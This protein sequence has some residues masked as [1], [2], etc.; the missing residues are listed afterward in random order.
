MVKCA[1]CGFLSVI[2]QSDGSYIGANRLYRL[3]GFQGGQV[4][5]VYCEPHCSIHAQDIHLEPLKAKGAG[6]QLSEIGRMVSLKTTDGEDVTDEAVLVNVSKSRDCDG[7]FLWRPGFSPKEHYEM[8]ER[9][10]WEKWQQEQRRK[11]RNSR[12]IEIGV[13]IA[14]AGIFTLLGSLI[15][16]GC[17]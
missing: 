12:I 16:R 17:I 15:A 10:R 2:S 5:E 6:I 11:D 3:E 7:F 8:L 4:D 1:D 14:G 13:L 9:Q